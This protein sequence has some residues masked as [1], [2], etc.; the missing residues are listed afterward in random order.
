VEGNLFKTHLNI[1]L[2]F[3]VPSRF[4]YKIRYVFPSVKDNETLKSD[5][6]LWNFS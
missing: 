2:H 4:P 5:D 1:I 6:A 3:R